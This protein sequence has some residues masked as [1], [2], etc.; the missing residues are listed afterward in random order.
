MGESAVET[1]PLAGPSQ[2]VRVESI[3]ESSYIEALRHKWIAS[4]AA[5]RD[6]GEAAISQWL[7]HHWKGWCRERWIEHLCGKVC[8]AE[9]DNRDFAALAR[10]FAGERQ[11]LESVLERIRA[12]SENLDI[13]IW[14]CEEGIDTTQVIN[15]LIIAD[16]NRLPLDHS[17]LLAGHFVA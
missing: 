5:G 6:L 8:W 9:F 10:K 4:E 16:I 7:Q 12:G 3:W 14:A 1:T 2:V 15:I 11:I 17:R 13:V